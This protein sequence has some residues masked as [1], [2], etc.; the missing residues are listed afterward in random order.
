MMKI[1][2]LAKVTGLPAHTLRFYEK[3]NLLTATQRSDNNYRVYTHEDVNTALFIQASRQIGFS[4]A[5]IKSLLS[6]RADKPAHMCA[7][8]KQITHQ[9][10]VE[11]EEQMQQLTKMLNALKRLN[12]SCCG[13]TESAEFCTIIEAMEL[14]AQQTEQES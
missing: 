5:E 14:K 1:G 2:E 7:D 13:G 8:A 11:I 9:K 10:I 3:N 12:D 4:L 6:I